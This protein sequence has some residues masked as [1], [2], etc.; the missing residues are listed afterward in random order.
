[1]IILD[2]KNI[3]GISKYL[4]KR[5]NGNNEERYLVKYKGIYRR[6]FK[7]SIDAYLFLRDIESGNFREQINQPEE[8]IIFEKKRIYSVREAAEKF[9][10][11]YKEEVRYGSYDKANSYLLNVVVPNLPNVSVSDLKNLDILEFRKK[12]SRDIKYVVKGKEPAPYSTGTKNYLITLIKQFMSFCINNFDTPAN[13]CKDIKQFKETREEK[14]KRNE[15]NE[16]MW[17]IKEYYSFM[18]SLKRM[19]GEYSVTYGAY[20]VMGNKGLR[21]GEVLALRYKDLKYENM[22]IVDES[23]T[24]KSENS[25]FEISNPKN[26]TS[27]RKIVISHGLYRYLLKLK[28]L[29]QRYPDYSD[30]WFIFHRPRVFDVPIA[31]QTLQNHKIKACKQIGLRLN[32]N[33]QL[34]HMYN[35]FLK[36]QGISVFDRSTV[37]GQKDAD[38][39]AEIY[40][41]MSED[42]L[43]KV[44]AADEKMFEMVGINVAQTL[45]KNQEV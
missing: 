22:L 38:V 45:Q 16:N 30:N 26:D 39:N 24:L 25:T 17:S 44:A 41:H 40:T 21:I 14:E 6:G 28:E 4:L 13:V 23:V 5:K 43:R 7:S 10:K 33:H 12:L 37:L 42:A 15:K 27:I 3:Y 8:K 32:T 1:M 29:D 35:T 20:L 9:L 2:G 19:Y 36:D 18:E 11:L 34:R 31:N